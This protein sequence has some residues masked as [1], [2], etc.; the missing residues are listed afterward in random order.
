[1]RIE[2]KLI[3]FFIALSLLFMSFSG[4]SKNSKKI[5][6]LYATRNW[7]S[8]NGLPSSAIL[9]IYQSQS[10]F[11][12]LL[13]YNGLV[14]YDGINFF[15]FDK[16]HPSYF[17]PN[18]V[19][20]IAETPD[21][22]LW[23]G[24]YGYGI[25]KYKNH[26]LTKIQT[27]DFFIQKLYAENNEKLWIGTKNS[28]LYLFITS[29]NK[30]T[31]IDFAPLNKTSINYIGKGP[32]GW[33]WLGTEN[34]GIFLYKDGKLKKF[35]NK[36][37]RALKQI[38]D[39][40]FLEN[41]NI[42]ISTYSGLYLVKNNRIRQIP[43]FAGLYIDQ[44]NQTNNYHLIVSTNHGIFQIN[45]QGKQ[46]KSFFKGNSIRVISTHEDE[47]KSL[48]VATYRNGLYQII[49]NQFK[50]FTTDE[51][52]S[53]NSIGGI[54]VLKNG[55]LLVGSIDGKINTIRNENVG[56]FNIKEPIYRQKIYG[57]FEDSKRNIW[58][59]TYKGL[60]KKY[61]N[62]Q[63]KKYTT[64]NGLK[65]NLCRMVY[66]DSHGDIW[67]A[68]RASG[69]SILRKNG[70]WKYYNKD[71]GLS[72]NF[73][74][75][76]N[77]DAD[78]NM[79]ICTDNGGLNIISPNGKI[80]IIDA[81]NGLSSDLCFT[82]T[83]DEDKSF[84]LAT[85]NGISHFKNNK[86]HHFNSNTGIPSDAIFDI[87]LDHKGCFWLSSN[88][89]VIK[90]KKQD[91]LDH[92]K[93][94]SKIINWTIYNKKSGL[95]SYECSGATK[96][97]IDKDGNI[98][99]PALDGLI[100][101]DPAWES[102]KDVKHQMVINSIKVNHITYNPDDEIL[103]NSSKSRIT[104]SFAYLS[105]TSPELINYQVQLKK[106]NDQWLD[107]GNQTQITY[108]NLPVGKYSFTVRAKNE[109]G[110]WGQASTKYKIHIKP[111]FTQT[112]WFYLILLAVAILLSIIFYK[113]RISTLH[114][115][116]LLLKDQV[117]GKTNEL[118]RNMDT[119]LQ[120]IVERKRIE[121]ELIASKEKA[122]TAN[123]SKSDFLANM[124]HEIRTP[125]NG[126]IGMTELL[127]Q[128]TLTAKQKDFTLTIQ[129]SANN[130]LN[131]INDIL[132]FSKIEAGQIDVENID[133]NIKNTINELIELFKFKINEKR[134]TFHYHISPEV[135]EWV[136]G[137]PHRLKQIII[138]LLNNA[139]KFTKEG[140]ISLR[141]YPIKTEKNFTR[142]R[143]DIIDTGIGIT[144]EGINKLFKSF[145]Q[146]D[147]STT[148]LFGGSGLG[149]AI[150]KNMTRLL[151]GEIGVE[152][153]VNIGSTFWFYIS[154]DKSN[155]KHIAR[156]SLAVD[157]VDTKTISSNT[158]SDK[159]YKILLAE[160]HPINQKVAQMHLKK[161]GHIVETADNGQI[162]LEMFTKNHYDLIF[163]DIQMPEMDGIEST[164]LIRE[165]EKEIKVKKPITIIALTANAMKGDKENCLRAGMN[166][167]M[168][169][170]F[171]PNE[172][173]RILANIFDT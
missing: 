129:Q 15:R 73:I 49:N 163:M 84:W 171:K 45:E 148:R 90:V 30:L 59:T 61:P 96:S 47:D 20:S 13:T 140:S 98:W 8:D 160:D 12:W 71:K 168:S 117:E 2:N 154:F 78:G 170:P 34:N 153:Q 4:Y 159:K 75:D 173:Q 137:D 66:E 79:L 81:S 94:S 100:C 149:L 33:V 110:T 41:G 139:I 42:F 52:L 106:Y 108:T 152:S 151:G 43:E 104:F 97:T 130:L 169:K 121:N 85:K 156:P 166:E 24:S 39:I 54:T 102:S 50:T 25:V 72:S 134:L 23:F 11:L 70:R 144:Q 14:K 116:E 150:S 18:S 112:V 77:E 135:P 131:L 141:V 113:L 118:Q 76:I 146:I 103:I 167:Y 58:I 28:G 82:T 119:L 22:T 5:V 115:K 132:D 157:E 21:S 31:K 57:L 172:L 27:P 17:S 127:K 158:R 86:I 74:L 162:A 120:E 122:D 80:K 69:I 10:G 19:F 136:K 114:Q 87:I 37:I 88:E 155:K 133:F 44:V 109:S 46:Y 38:Q 63:E 51:G 9:D 91:L 138:N 92:E 62:G 164:K 143:F 7:T 53:T 145:S 1:M 32:K 107:I 83:L 93:N 6:S 147:S 3:I 124:S 105:F 99:I 95:N 67:I 165:F 123:K 26:N 40:T 142:I 128:T 68:T 64:A 161:L 35:D 56:V 60:I 126:I 29:K 16:A 101:I 36:N 55:K 111:G 65:G 125:M 48:W 89:G